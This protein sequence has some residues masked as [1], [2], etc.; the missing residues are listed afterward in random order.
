[1]APSGSGKGAL[2]K[3][4]GELADQMYFAKTFTSRERRNGAAE[5]PKY[6][7]I[8]REKFEHMIKDGVFVEWAEFSGNL[9]GTSKEDVLNALYNGEVVFKEMELQG[10]EQM[11]KIVGDEYVTV[12]YVEAG[13]WNALERRIRSR[14]VISDEE[15]AMRKERYKEELKAKDIADVVIENKDGQL[16]EAQE[17]FRQTVIDIIKDVT[18]TQVS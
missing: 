17:E 5:N 7:F 18:G 1:M 16:E 10:I 9:Y 6:N 11:K 8:S 2:V 4:L 12:V 14:A 3:S 15:L 13:G